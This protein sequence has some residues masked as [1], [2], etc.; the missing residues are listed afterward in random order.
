[1]N[2]STE[3]QSENT[4][5]I[6]NVGTFASGICAV[7]CG[8]AAFLPGLFTMVGLDMLAG[9]EAEWGFT[10]VAIGFALGAMIL[11]WQKHR[12]PQ[13]VGLFAAGIIGLLASR[14]LEEMGEHGGHGEQAH[15]AQ[16]AEQEKHGE[17]KDAH[18]DHHDLGLG[19]VLGLGSGALLVFSH[20]KNAAAVRN[21]SKDCCDT[22]T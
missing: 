8:L 5:H 11:G 14:F 22:P 21:C 16:K 4:T 1:M 9:H 15:H 13:I 19:I 18:G 6:D 20:I 7:H 17:E 3:N 2:A 12:T 10:I